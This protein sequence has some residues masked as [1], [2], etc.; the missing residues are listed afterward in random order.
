[1]ARLTRVV[2]ASCLG[3]ACGN[4]L[5]PPGTCE[6]QT[7][8]ETATVESVALGGPAGYD[9]LAFSHVLGKV[10]AAPEGTGRV[11]LVDPDSMAVTLIGVPA[12]SAS[13]DASATTVFVVDRGGA[14]ILA[15]DV[16]SAAM[17]A[18]HP[19]AGEPDYVRVAPTTGEIWVTVPGRNRI[20]ILEPA[21]LAAVG[22]ITTPGP[23]EGL[24]FDDAGR[25]YVNN[26]GAVVAID[27]ARRL[28]VGEWDDGCG[29]SHGFPQVDLAYG[30]AIGGCRAS[31]GAGVTTIDGELRAGFEAGGDAAVLAYDAT[32]HHLYL[33]GDPGSTLSILAVCS[34][35]EVSEL[36]KVAIPD[37]GH[38]AA[39]DASGHVWIADATTGGLVRVTDPFMGTQ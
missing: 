8:G 5:P 29:Y 6:V 3:A 24:T 1:M 32:R 31:G 4:S 30:L 26:D 12:G 35:G 11:Y 36:A 17:L 21:G 34:T 20:D 22:S 39:A 13:A 18:S 38:A 23:P 37:R 2:F 33:R 14:R 16:A 25:A 27:V 7:A 10:V 15:F 28:V 19:I 9:D